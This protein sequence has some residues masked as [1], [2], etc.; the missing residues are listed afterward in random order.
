MTFGHVVRFQKSG[1]VSSESGI[2]ALDR[3]H[4]RPFFAAN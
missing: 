2:L 1:E 3:T 4:Y